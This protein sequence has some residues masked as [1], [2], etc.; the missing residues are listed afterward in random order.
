MTD[1]DIFKNEFVPNIESHAKLSFASWQKTAPIDYARWVAFRDAILRGETP[2]APLM[3]TKYGKALVATGKMA[4]DVVVPPPPPPTINE[5]HG[6]AYMSWGNGY[7]PTIH[8]NDY[9]M[10]FLSWGGAG[11]V[12]T[13]GITTKTVV[14]MSAVSCLENSGWHYGVTGEDAIANNWVLKEG[15]RLLR[16]AG[17]PTSYIGDP[18]SIGYQ[19]RWCN[20]VIGKIQEWGVDG[21]FID[22]F[23]GSLSLADGIPDKYPTKDLQRTALFSFIKYV[24]NQMKS[25]GIKVYTNSVVYEGEMGDDAG[26]TTIPWWTMIAPHVDG[27]CAEYWQ[28]RNNSTQKIRKLGPEWYN[29]WD[30][31]QALP[32]FC[33]SN[34]KEFIGIMY[35]DNYSRPASDKVYVLCSMLLETT[36]GSIVSSNSSTNPWI[37]EYDLLPLG[38]PLGTKIQNGNRWQRQYERGLIWVDPTLGTSGII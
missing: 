26:L 20:N 10:L 17:Y 21:V 13:S 27:L 38:N 18:G 11:K 7:L 8:K 1:L 33:E 34:S 24:Y 4:Y 22:D 14:Y 12:A 36:N 31:W 32:A 23:Y 9:D 16:N 25:A 6:V 3:T 15:T 29:H 30:T 28:W 35:S 5:K 37:P 19:Q 2:V